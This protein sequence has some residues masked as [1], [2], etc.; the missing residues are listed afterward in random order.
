[1]NDLVQKRAPDLAR[2]HAIS[3]E[4]D[5]QLQPVLDGEAPAFVL[6]LQALSDGALTLVRSDDSVRELVLMSYG[7]DRRMVEIVRG[8]MIP[9]HEVL[10]NGERDGCITFQ[11][12]CSCDFY[13]HL[14]MRS[15]RGGIGNEG[16]FLRFAAP[17]SWD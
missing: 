15:R 6:C 14:E 12:P 9:V 11:P 7:R 5:G 8:Q 16:L 10:D 3:L 2:G 4:L 17:N 1:M 13:I